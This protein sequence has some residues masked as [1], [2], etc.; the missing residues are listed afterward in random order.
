MWLEVVWVTWQ[1]VQRETTSERPEEGTATPGEPEGTA[2]PAEP[3][4]TATPG[5][6][7]G[8]ATPA[9]PEG[10][11]TPA[12]PEGTATPAEPCEWKWED[13]WRTW[14]TP[15]TDLQQQSSQGKLTCKVGGSERPS[16]YS[17]T[18]PTLNQDSHYKLPAVFLD[19]S[20]HHSHFT[21]SHTT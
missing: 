7:E 11:A 13:T 20:S 9:E 17:A 19:I 2:T 12:E 21:S 18:G 14:A 6:P 16:R 4:G 15:W 5:E 1:N 10:T 3:E 8:T